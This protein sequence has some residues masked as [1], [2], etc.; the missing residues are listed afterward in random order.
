MDD[1][2]DIRSKAAAVCSI[3]NP[4]AT[5][6]GQTHYTMSL[7]S[8]MATSRLCQILTYEFKDTMIL[9][10][11]AIYRLVGEN[12]NSM[13]K[14]R[15]IEF[16]APDE[17]LATNN[18]NLRKVPE[19]NELALV[20]FCPFDEMLHRAKKQDDVLFVEEKQNLFVD[21]VREADT[22]ADVL[23]KT[24]PSSRTEDIA[25]EFS[26]WTLGGLKALIKAA[27]NEEDGPLGWTSKP[28]VFSLGVRIILAA[29]V[30]LSWASRRSSRETHSL[31]LRELLQELLKIG[32]QALIHGI[33]LQR[34]E[35]TLEEAL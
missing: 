32:R 1:D 35:E 22:W 7:S 21:S 4:S 28:E 34:I 9:S 19:T 24:H 6:D 3:L 25:I 27:R 23:M 11:E 12:S 33:W 26:N 18:T 10:T 16:A 17:L 8:P 2:E 20:P 29:K 31:Q 14:V 30:Q 5:A 13:F 15:P